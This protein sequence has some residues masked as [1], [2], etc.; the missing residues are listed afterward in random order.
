MA[1]SPMRIIPLMLLGIFLFAGCAARRYQASPI[2]PIATAA[3][4]ESRSLADDGLRHYE[5]KNL[6][7]APTSWPLRDWNLQTLS[8]AALY[9]SPG[10]DAARARVAR[11]DAA[12][13]TAGARPNPVLSFSPGVPSPYLVSLD[14]SFPIETAGKRGYRV[15]SS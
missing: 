1:G 2:A 10:L 15:A 11:A 14:F 8:L 6:N 9:F 13:T 12:M 3:Q 4:L 7:P 5:E